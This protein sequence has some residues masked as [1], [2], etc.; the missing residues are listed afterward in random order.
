MHV[1]RRMPDKTYA[2]LG[3]FKILSKTTMK[4]CPQPTQYLRNSLKELH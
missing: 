2:N 4:Y 3:N 1:R